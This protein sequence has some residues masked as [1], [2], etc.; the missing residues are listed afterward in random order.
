[1]ANIWE[2]PSII[3][4]E[5]LRHMEDRL[6]IANL[7]ARDKTAEFNKTYNGWGVGDTVAF[8]T[9]GEYTVDDYTE[10]GNIATQNIA[11]STRNLTIE[12]HYD[13]SVSVTAREERLDLDS[14]SE[15][16]IRPAAYKM[17]ETVDTYIGTKIMEGQGLYTTA[18]LF[19]SA[20]DI[21]LARKAATIQQLNAD[22]FCLV[23]L[24][25]EADLLGQTWF[26]QSQTRG[27]EGL[28]TL[29]SG[30]MGHVMGMDF[31]SSI[32]FPESTL[33]VGTMICATNNTTG[34]KNLIGDTVLTVDTQTA[35]KTLV[36]GDRLAIAGVRRPLVVASAEADTSAV[37]SITLAH[38]ITEVIPDDA[39]V[40]V[41][42][43]TTD[44]TYHGAIF[45][46]QTLAVAMPLLDMPG[47]RVTATASNNGIS[48]RIVKGYDLTT[49]TTTMS[50]DLIIGAFCLDTRKVT[51]LGQGV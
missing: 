11:T 41:I 2:H 20:S 1:M 50:M 51:L 38:P 4:M 44:V 37:I 18:D 32:A 33:T 27:A 47:D 45:D 9:H 43:S 3:A 34:T 24:T 48:I 42:G 14:F 12:K 49:K 10:G 29:R 6:V 19:A 16:V 15:Q 25:T 21:A 7:C 23:D 36:I 39:A 22:R 30:Q 40:T 26:N 5:A 31:F 8:R 35:S 46:G 28:S 17:A 13:V